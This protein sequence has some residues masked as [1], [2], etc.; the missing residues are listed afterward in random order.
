MAR[1]HCRRA[2]EMGDIVVAIL[3]NVK[4]HNGCEKTDQV[5]EENSQGFN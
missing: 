2:G 1:S 3:E 5:Q 4:S